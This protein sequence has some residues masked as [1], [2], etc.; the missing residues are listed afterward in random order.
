VAKRGTRRAATKPR[1]AASRRQTRPAAPGPVQALLSAARDYHEHS[2]GLALSFLL[3]I[4][5]LAMYEVGIALLRA[6]AGSA[7]GMEVRM[8]FDRA[9]GPSAALV[10]NGVI[11][12]GF[13]GAFVYLRMRRAVRVDLLPLLL[14]ESVVYALVLFY[15]LSVLTSQLPLSAYAG[16]R[17]A[18][19]IALNVVLSIGAGVYEEIVFRLA[20]M[21]MLYAVAMLLVPRA[22]KV[23]APAIVLAS[24]LVFSACHYFVLGHEPFGTY[25]FLYRFFFGL[26]LSAIYIYRGLGV[27]VYTH[28]IY[29]IAVSLGY[30]L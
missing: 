4:P 3:V 16:V 8:L 22:G 19:S 9:F 21:S 23:F 11:L 13:I 25:D 20:L 15:G 24:A 5:L 17:G 10:F 27:A 2:R 30:G 26:A 29:D 1:S 14:V 12:A 6:P 7:T 28:A 18:D